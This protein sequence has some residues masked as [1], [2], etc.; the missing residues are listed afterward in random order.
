MGSIGHELH[1]AIEVLSDPRIKSRDAMVRLFTNEGSVVNGT[2]ETYAA[3][4][5]GSAV[6][7]EVL[8]ALRVESR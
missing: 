8:E 4:D 5:K 7:L 2:F 1:H 6:R 3:V